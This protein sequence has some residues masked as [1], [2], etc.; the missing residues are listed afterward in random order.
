VTVDAGGDWSG[1]TTG[2]ALAIEFTA[3][4]LEASLARAV[5]GFADAL[6]EIHP[7]MVTERHGFETRAPTPSALLLAVLEECL[8]CRREGRY[9]VSLS[10]AVFVD[11]LFSAGIDTVSADDPRVHAA[12]PPVISWHEVSLESAPGGAWTGRIVAR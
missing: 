7:S 12:L 2:H 8:R 6:G 4:T 11:D 3:P 10:D 5:E 9:A 1:G